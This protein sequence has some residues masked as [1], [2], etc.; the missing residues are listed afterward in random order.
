MSQVVRHSPVLPQTERGWI[1][2]TAQKG[3]GLDDR[4]PSLCPRARRPGPGAR[5]S[6]EGQGLC[7]PVG[8]STPPGAFSR[9]GSSRRSACLLASYTRR[10]DDE[11]DD[12]TPY[13]DDEAIEQEQH[14]EDLDEA[15]RERP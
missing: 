12:G 4:G 5:H 6:T 10:V 15:L 8:V 7:N 11:E 14:E 3:P 1:A 2:A 13:L 9:D